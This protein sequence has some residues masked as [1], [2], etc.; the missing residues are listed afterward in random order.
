VQQGGRAPQQAQDELKVV[1]VSQMKVVMG[2]DT[3]L[4][5]WWYGRRRAPQQAQDELMVGGV[6]IDSLSPPGDYGWHSLQMPR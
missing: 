5:P 6:F 3:V 1:D 4:R 2:F